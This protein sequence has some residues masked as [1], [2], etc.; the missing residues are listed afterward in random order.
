MG[1]KQCIPM[2]MILLTFPHHCK[3]KTTQTPP[4]KTVN[5]IHERDPLAL[6]EINY[7]SEICQEGFPKEKMERRSRKK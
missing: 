2:K 3:L 7:N 6:N 4:I 1:L 5:P